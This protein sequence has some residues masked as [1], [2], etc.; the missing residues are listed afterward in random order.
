MIILLIILLLL[1]YLRV[2]QDIRVKNARLEIPG[3]VSVILSRQI[4]RIVANNDNFYTIFIASTS[5][6]IIFNRT[7]SLHEI[8]MA[9][10]GG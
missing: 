10:L 8:L 6:I 9:N 2:L 5:L 4:E 1:L 3:K 7:K